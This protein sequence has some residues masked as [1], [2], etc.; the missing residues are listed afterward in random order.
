MNREVKFIYTDG[1]KNYK[2]FKIRQNTKGELFFFPSLFNSRLVGTQGNHFT[3]HEAGYYNTTLKGRNG[4][5][6]HFKGPNLRPIS[7]FKGVCK[8]YVLAREPLRLI[9]LKLWIHKDERIRT[10]LSPN[11]N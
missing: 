2:F 1:V 9:Y 3:Y 5:C 6:S 4:F 8:S 7:E 10:W 11:V